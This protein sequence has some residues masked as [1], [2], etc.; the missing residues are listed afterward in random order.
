MPGILVNVQHTRYLKPL[1]E[2]ASEG[3][4]CGNAARPAFYVIVADFSTGEWL[5]EYNSATGGYVKHR[6]R[7]FNDLTDRPRSI[8][9][10]ELRRRIGTGRLSFRRLP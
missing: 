8:T 10:V 6:K 7:C 3:W 5:G 4:G 1:I 9:D 2:A